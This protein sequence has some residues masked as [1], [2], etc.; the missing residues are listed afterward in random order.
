M[1]KAFFRAALQYTLGN[2][3]VQSCKG[4]QSWPSRFN[5]APTLFKT[6]DVSPLEGR[7]CC[8]PH[9]V[10]SSVPFIEISPF[11]CLPICWLSCSIREV[12]KG[13][14]STIFATAR[15]QT[16][17]QN[18]ILHQFQLVFKIFI[19]CLLWVFSLWVV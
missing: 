9:L 13:K 11:Y 18:H 15:D 8:I 3:R 14:S 19:C 5:L 2:S 17:F 7:A 10:F 6:D 4:P 12:F 1:V 16:S